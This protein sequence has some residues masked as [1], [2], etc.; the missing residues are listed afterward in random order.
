VDR[1][2]Y[3][4]VECDTVQLASY[5]YSELQ[6]AELERSAN[7]LNLSFVPDDMTF[8][9][10]FRSCQ[11]LFPLTVDLLRWCL[12]QRPGHLCGRKDR[13]STPRLRDGCEVTCYK[14]FVSVLTCMQALRHSKV[15]LTWDQD[16]P[17][18]E[19]VTRR[20]LSLKE[21]EE[22][23]FH[24][25]VASSTDS[26][27]DDETNSAKNT[28]SRDKLRALLLD[29]R[30]N[31]L[32]EGWA[33]S[34]TGAMNEEGDG[35]D[36]DMEVTFRPAL[37][38]GQDEEETTIGRYQRKMREKR[39]KWKQELKDAGRG[40]AP[41]DDF[42]VRSEGEGD[43]AGESLR[44][45]RK[46]TRGEQRN[47]NRKPSTKEELSLLVA[48]DQ[49]GSEPKHFDMAAIIKAEKKKGKKRRGRR[50]ETSGDD[51]NE[52]QDDF[53]ID[54]KDERFRA[55]HEDYAFAIDPSNPHFKK[56][57]SMSALLEERSKR[58]KVNG[59]APTTARISK[60]GTTQSL[61]SLVESVK[62][63]NAATSDG[64]GAKRKKF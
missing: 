54:V 63:R 16:D 6:G 1:Y 12:K 28:V 8:E 34:K 40:E 55:L 38:G 48:P 11:P 49:P 44:G 33:G 45:G 5:L 62:R 27:T 58:K 31:D 3:A 59:E 25:Y 30:G 46:D 56:T 53:A 57:E 9:E 43:G 2:Y 17:E 19:R 15:K 36:M 24:A 35:N 60:G 18:R 51:E 61:A 4:I 39:K 26:S 52:L 32:P 50:K 47:K 42:F 13:L 64:G 37:S 14:I 23:D 7:V 41:A 20:A 29:V 22:N 21:I 10:V